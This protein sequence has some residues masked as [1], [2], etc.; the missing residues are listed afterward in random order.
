MNKKI[1]A[2]LLMSPLLMLIII[3]TIIGV[4]GIFYLIRAI[5]LDQFALGW[6]MQDTKTGLSIIGFFA[7]I[8]II[9]KMFEKGVKIY[10]ENSKKE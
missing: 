10:K 1:K 5:V 3:G 6:T 2:L 7:L 4:I 8:T 9:F